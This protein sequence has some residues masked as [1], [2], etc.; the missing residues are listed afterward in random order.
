MWWTRFKGKGWKIWGQA[1]GPGDFRSQDLRFQSC[2]AK[3]RVSKQSCMGSS[4]HFRV[5][6]FLGGIG[7][8]YVFAGGIILR[9]VLQ[10][11]R[12]EAPSL[13]P[14]KSWFRRIVL[15][16]AGVGILCFLYGY[17][18]EPYWLSVTHIRVTSAK[19]PKGAK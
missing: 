17:F 6:V 1:E 13:A 11:I 7:A 9:R 2:F 12:G 19:L 5:L 16:F 18:C 4:E 10:K 15:T 3:L 8:V 14:A